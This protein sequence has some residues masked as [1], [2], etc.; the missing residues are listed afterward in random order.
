MMLLMDMLYVTITL[1][2][3]Y[4]FMVMLLIEKM[5]GEKDDLDYCCYF[6]TI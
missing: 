6:V 5:P 2:L 4:Y 3:F 1:T